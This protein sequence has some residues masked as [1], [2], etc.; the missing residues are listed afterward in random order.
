MEMFIPICD[1]EKWHWLVSVHVRVQ[2]FSPPYVA[3]TSF[4]ST[5]WQSASV[6]HGARGGSV[7]FGGADGLS[8][9]PLTHTLIPSGPNRV[10]SQ[11][12]PDGQLPHSRVQ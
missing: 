12:M 11:I 5:A 2:S 9:A 10:L 1:V 7:G 3:H 8:C 4:E 6:E